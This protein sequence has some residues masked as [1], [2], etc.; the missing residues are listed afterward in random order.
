MPET[1]DIWFIDFGAPEPGQPA[2][3]RPALLLAPSDP[4]EWLS[5]SFLMVP[6]TTTDRDYAAAVEVRPSDANG[7]PRRSFAQVDMMRTLPDRAC[8]TFVGRLDPQD[9]AIIRFVVSQYMGYVQA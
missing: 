9:W 6:F 2:F 4:G 7:L 3:R 8:R 5:T 1:G